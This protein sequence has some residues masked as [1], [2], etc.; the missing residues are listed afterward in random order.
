MFEY[1]HPIPTHSD[2]EGFKSCLHV[3]DIID[4]VI[5]RDELGMQDEYL[6]LARGAAIASRYLLRQA[7][8]HGGERPSGWHKHGDFFSTL[9][10]GPILLCISRFGDSR[11]WSIHRHDGQIPPDILVFGFGSTPIL[12]RSEASAMRRAMHCGPNEPPNGLR[13][14]NPSPQDLAGALQVATKRRTDEAVAANGARSPSSGSS[15]GTKP[16]CQT[17]SCRWHEAV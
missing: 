4:E 13:W 7:H 5:D 10:D 3:L 15:T 6:P 17:S 1:N 8:H 16:G 14:N 9:V 2:W 11:F 12:T